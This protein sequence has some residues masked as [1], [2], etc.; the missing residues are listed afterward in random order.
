MN[1]LQWMA[2]EFQKLV[3][4]PGEVVWLPVDKAELDPRTVRYLEMGLDP[5][6][7]AY[8]ICSERVLGSVLFRL[9]DPQVRYL[10][11]DPESLSHQWGAEG[12]HDALDGDE[13]FN[14]MCQ[15]AGLP[16]QDLTGHGERCRERAALL[17]KKAVGR[18]SPQE[19][20]R[21]V[22]LQTFSRSMN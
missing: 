22:Y 2:D 8:E 9:D 16:V 15:R 5:T 12:F 6:G 3:N 20:Q 11:H 14:Y 21:Y 13:V 4:T 18:L 7:I 17:R 19:Q 10:H 1:R